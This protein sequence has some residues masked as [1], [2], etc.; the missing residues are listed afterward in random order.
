MLLPNEGQEERG[1]GISTSCRS[2]C[3][4]ALQPV[5]VCTVDFTVG[6]LKVVLACN[7]DIASSIDQMVIGFGSITLGYVALGAAI[8]GA[9]GAG[10]QGRG[11][12]SKPTS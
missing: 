7:A 9:D 8:Y 10:A 5:G 6:A 1:D 11:L 3:A 2:Y 12:Y 4:G